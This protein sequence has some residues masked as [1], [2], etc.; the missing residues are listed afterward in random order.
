MESV[1]RDSGVTTLSQLRIL[2]VQGANRNV[3]YYDGLGRPMQT[4]QWQGSPNKKDIV[5]HIEYDNF[6]RES[7]KYLPYVSLGIDG[8]YKA[9]GSVNVN[10]FYTKTTGDDIS[11]IVR[12]PKPYAETVFENSP[13][14]RVLQ[15]GASGEAWQP[16]ANRELV[17]T[18][19]TTG[20]TVAVDYGTN[21]DSSVLFW[22]VNDNGNG[23]TAETGTI[24][25]YYVP[26]RLYKTVT[27]DENWVSDNG[28]GGTVEEYRDFGDRVVL[29]RVWKS[30]TDSLSTYYV[31]DDYGDLCY[32]IPPGYTGAT[33]TET[34]SGDFHELVYAYKYDIRRRLIEKKIPGKGWEYLVYNDRD[35]PV[36]SQDAMQRGAGKWS[37]TKYDALGKVVST[38]IYTN[39]SLTSQLLAQNAV[40]SHPLVNGVRP[41]WED[42]IGTAD[43]TNKAFPTSGTV[44]YVTNYYD[45]YAFTGAAGLPEQGITKSSKTKTLVTGTKVSKDDGTAPLLTVNYYDDRGRL[46]QSASQNHLGGTD[47]VTNRYNF[48]GELLT[49]KREHKASPAGATTTVLTTNTYDHVGR[50]VDTRKKVNTQAEV[51]QSRSV[52][53]EIGQLKQK[54]LHSENSGTNFI[55][56]ADYTYNERGWTNRIGSLHFTEELRYND[57]ASGGMVQYNGNISQQLWGHSDT[58]NSTF[59]YTYDKLNRLENGTSTGTMMSE[60]LT[61]DD[62]G[63]ISTL[64]RDNGTAINYGY[65]GNRLTSL[66]GGLSGSYTYNANG[67]ALT[68]RTGMAFTYNHLNLPKTATKSGTSVA[69]LYDASGAKLRKTA[70]VSGTTGQRDYIGGIEYNKVGSAASTI[71]MIH[72]EEGYLQNSGGTYTYHYNLTDHLGNVR[73]T[74]QRTTA[75]TGAVIQKHDYYPFGKSKAIVTSGINKYLYNGKEVQGELGG[76]LDYGARFY[77]AEIGRWNV[78]D[79]LAEQ[80]RRH[81]PYNYAFNNPIRFID[82]DGMAPAGVESLL[83]WARTASAMEEGRNRLESM[84]YGED[85]QEDPPKKKLSA[86]EIAKLNQESID[87]QYDVLTKFNKGLLG[88]R[89][90]FAG[91]GGE[92]SLRA[93]KGLKGGWLPEKWGTG[94]LIIE[95]GGN[96]SASEIAAANYMKSQGYRVFLRKPVGT[97]AAGQTSDLVVNGIN[98]DVYTPVT[99]NVNRIVSAVASKNTQTTGVVID[100]S[101]TNVVSSQLSNLL[102]R[103]QGTGAT[104]IKNIIIMPK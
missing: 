59:S 28:R 61:Y 83:M 54:R 78:V 9:G 57:P 39:T 56:S 11:G 20:H 6:G 87:W 88:I 43:Y 60:I 12:T 33:V 42:R 79:P 51:I 98:Y 16:E 23:A 50:L 58:T 31:Y 17:T 7:K 92:K 53:N 99:S 8:S 36:L 27:K 37:Y 47:Y 48:P 19:S 40:N 100:L 68:D 2:P 18:A 3:Q 5:Q 4:V 13:L 65:T 76:L 104:N 35:Q 24:K 94:S 72:T 26:G 29:K 73:A 69:Y 64:T 71:E 91:F 101:E 67:N 74:L 86:E 45:D 80:M 63:N 70:T 102:Q 44:A 77:D 46:I 97:R 84:M 34:P 1:V 22:K 32:V 82:P 55:N 75:T 85:D 14:D 49:S 41:L 25:N 93:V 52:Y 90:L 89:T 66:S 95:A 15:Q 30:D 103:V 38:G 81:S 21:R 62:M 10:T 96:F